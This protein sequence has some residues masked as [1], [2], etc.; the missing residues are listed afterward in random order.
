M[1]RNPVLAWVLLVPVAHLLAVAHEWF[2]F[3][4][5]VLDVHLRVGPLRG[6]YAVPIARGSIGFLIELAVVA[7]V[8]AFLRRRLGVS[9]RAALFDGAVHLLPLG[10]A[11]LLLLVG[12]GQ[13]RVLLLAA[14]VG[15]VTAAAILRLPA[16]AAETAD[17]PS[18]WPPRLAASLATLAAVWYAAIMYAQ[19]SSYWTSVYDLGL[20]ASALRSTVHGDGF[21]YTPM[22]GCTFLAEHFSPVLALLAPLYMLFDHP[23]TL[24]VVQSVSMAGAGYLVYR[25][26]DETLGDRWVALAFCASWLVLPDTLHAQW[27]GFKMDLLEPPMVLGAFLA[28]RRGSDRWF[29]LCVA[30]LWATKEDAFVATTALGLYAWAAHGRRRTGL[31]VVVAGVVLGVVL[32]AWVVPAYADF[33]LAGDYV[34]RFTED[35]Y[36]FSS[37]FGHLGSDLPRAVVG[38]VTNPLYVIGHLASGD[39]PA[40]LLTLVAP[41]GFLVLAGGWRT[42]LLLVPA[43]EMLLASFQ[44]M[45]ALD[46]YYAARPLAFAYAGAIVGLGAL[47]AAAGPG[48]PA[49]HVPA[50]LGRSLRAVGGPSAGRIGAAAAAYLVAA[51]L[52]LAWLD[53]DSPVSPVHERPAYITTPRT[54]VM[55]EVVESVPSDVPAAATANIGIHLTDRLGPDHLPFGL[56]DVEYVVM[57]LYRSSFP[58]TRAGLVAFAGALAGKPEWGVLRADRGVLLFRRGASRELNAAAIEMIDTPVFEAEDWYSSHFPNLAIRSADASNGAALRVTPSDRRGPGL[59]L[60]VEEWP[61]RPGEYEASF[62]LAA[63]R[64]EHEHPLRTAATIGVYLGG[65]LVSGAGLRFADFASPGAWQEFGLRFRAERDRGYEF[66]VYYHD[67]G[68]VALDAIRVSRLGE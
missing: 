48:G 55:D 24:Q 53:P 49:V 22:F 60:L 31:A 39:R 57:D 2:Y 64:E 46:Y 21:L 16:P 6:E 33:R 58:M 45:Y 30:L 32:L 10:F 38:A 52:M 13:V 50:A 62:R 56:K 20:F 47:R 3:P 35:G 34:T 44:Y 61:L 12:H 40:G 29:L 63:E 18:R 5:V 59:L 19:Y 43:L 67:F 11:P 1:P 4:P 66:R 36:K 8:I 7:L 14:L 41:L 54:K 26:A 28:L 42:L 37:R 25:L 15:G 68:A 51:A 9:W 23:M 65:A 27:H 17:L